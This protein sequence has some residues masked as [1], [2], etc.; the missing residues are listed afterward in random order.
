MKEAKKD[1]GDFFILKMD[2]KK[3]FY[4]INQSI[5]FDII[6]KYMCDK[7][8]L[9]LSSKLIFSDREKVG[10]PIGNYTSQY[11]AN[12]YLNELDYYV[13]HKLK[14]KYYLRFMDDFIILVDN[15]ETAKIVFKK[16]ENFI[17][18]NLD[19]DL[20]HK[21]RYFPSS[22]GIDFCGY[23]VFQTH[24]LIRN[25]SKKRMRKRI[26]KWNK[27]YING[28]LDLYSVRCSLNSWTSHIKHANSYNLYNRYMNKISFSVE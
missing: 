12:M 2:I 14:I 20:N 8:L 1:Y 5:L 13:K 17:K 18:I 15:K 27:L 19:L 22:M 4:S 28:E 7:K 26:K 6:K 11:F 3:F 16:V 21:S 23:R 25:S 10:I 24:K 9:E